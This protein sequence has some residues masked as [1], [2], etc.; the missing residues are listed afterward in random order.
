LELIVDAGAET[1]TVSGLVHRL[2]RGEPLPRRTVVITFD[3]G[4]L[5]TLDIAAP[6]L[7]AKGLVATVYLTTG[8]LQG[9][10]RGSSPHAPG[11]MVPWDRLHELEAAGL[12]LGAHTHGHPQL[13]VLPSREATAEVRTSKVLLEASLGHPVRSFAYPH[14]YTSAWL[15]SEVQRA[16]FESE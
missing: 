2:R 14:G 10:T 5:D 11:A 3:D 7:R 9:G 1:L 8:Y 16:G 15:R 13:D 4:F 12:E 6:R